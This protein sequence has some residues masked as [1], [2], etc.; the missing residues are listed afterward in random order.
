MNKPFFILCCSFLCFLCFEAPAQMKN[1][2]NQTKNTE[3]IFVTGYMNYPPFGYIEEYRRDKL[4]KTRYAYHSIFDGVMD[5]LKQNSNLKL[6]YLYSP[7]ASEDQFLEDINSGK[8]DIFLGVYYDTQKFRR[9]ELVYPSLINNPVIVIT[10]PEMAEKIGNLAEL[11]QLKGAICTQERLSDYVSKQLKDYSLEYVDTPLEMFQKLYTGEVD[12][13]FATQY[14]GI[15]EAAKLGI[16][17][18]LSFSKQIIW[19]MPVFIGVS[20]LSKSRK[21]LVQK[22]SS[23]SE[24]PLNRQ[25]IEKRLQDLI[26]DIELKNQGLISPV[27]VKKEN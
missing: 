18:Q 1:V 27:F 11:K 23:Y 21:F 17:K 4:D 5:E 9:T 7:D 14:F 20:Q 22:L 10:L 13:V 12:Y 19:N 8:T 15:I 16:R 2:T 6:T 25:K 24:N 26:Y 3:T